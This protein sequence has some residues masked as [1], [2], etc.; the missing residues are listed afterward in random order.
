M[1]LFISAV[2]L[3][4]GRSNCSSFKQFC[5]LLL[6]WVI[7]VKHFQV[8]RIIHFN[9]IFHFNRVGSFERS[10]DGNLRLALNPLLLYTV[11]EKGS[12]FVSANIKL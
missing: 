1:E 7:T 8:S 9:A 11:K 4:Y 12:S 6:G 3:L 5:W 2:S 10:P